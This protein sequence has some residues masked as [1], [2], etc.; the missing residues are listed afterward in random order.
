MKKTLR[1]MIAVPLVA[2]FIANCSIMNT[3]TNLG[4]MVVGVDFPKKSFSIKKI[5]LKTTKILL[6]ISGVGFTNTLQFFLTPDA[7]KIKILMIAG[8]KNIT[9]TAFDDTSKILAC[10]K[11]SIVIK[12]GVDNKLEIVLVE[13][14]TPL[15]PS[16]DSKNT[17]DDVTLP[18][19][20]DKPK[21][22]SNSSTNGSGTNG[23]GT[24][25]S[26]T[27]GSGTNGS[28]TNGSGTNGSG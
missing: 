21:D 5:P 17:T 27:N 12:N 13:G 2:L 6:E 19:V 16:T 23:S 20:I 24:N 11:T 25:G 28:G 22:P 14:T 10:T 26:G 9:V 4:Y 18:I 15:E 3:N 8:N 7:P 1:F